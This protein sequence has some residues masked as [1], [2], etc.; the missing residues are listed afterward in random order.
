MGRGD[1]GEAERQKEKKEALVSRGGGERAR[2]H[3]GRG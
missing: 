1:A 2:G 3:G